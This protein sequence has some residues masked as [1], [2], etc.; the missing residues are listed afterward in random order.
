M[1]NH[2]STLTYLDLAR[3][4][5]LWEPDWISRAEA[6]GYFPTLQQPDATSTSVT[7]SDHVPAT[8]P[9]YSIKDK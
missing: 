4:G 5:S 7:Q 8:D 1:Q 3:S 9:P 2:I 6:A